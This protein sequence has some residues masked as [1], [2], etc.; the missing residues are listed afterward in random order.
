M[1]NFSILQELKMTCTKIFTRI[2]F[3][4]FPGFLKFLMILKFSLLVDHMEVSWLPI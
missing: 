4:F 3:I 2:D 1:Q